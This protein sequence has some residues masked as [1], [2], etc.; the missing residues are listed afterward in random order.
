MTDTIELLLKDLKRDLITFRTLERFINKHDNDYL[1][2]F[3][4]GGF[5]GTQDKSNYLSKKFDLEYRKDDLNNFYYER[6]FELCNLKGMFFWHR[7][8][9]IDISLDVAKEIFMFVQLNQ[10]KINDYQK[11]QKISFIQKD[12]LIAGV[13]NKISNRELRACPSELNDIF[14]FCG[15]TGFKIN[16]YLNHVTIQFT[17]EF[18]NAYW[19]LQNKTNEANNAIKSLI[20]IIIKDKEE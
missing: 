7:R 13:K 17:Q 9:V 6:L 19:A 2:G 15:L 12:W 20:N 5:F 3:S 18:I 11:L 10:S 4:H 1:N 16:Q 14:N 8:N